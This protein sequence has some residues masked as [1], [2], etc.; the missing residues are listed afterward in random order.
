MPSIALIGFMGTGKTAVGRVLAERLG[1]EFIDLDAVIEEQ[2]GI[3]IAEIFRR[4]GE[5]HF[6]KLEQ[7][8]VAE[9]SQR[10][11]VVLAAG[12]GAVLDR[13]NV[14]NLKRMGPVVHLMAHPEM[15]VRRIAG[16]H[17]RPL[18]EVEDRRGRIENL[19]A[20]RLPFYAVADMDIDTSGL[21]VKK[22]VERIIGRLKESDTG[23]ID[24]G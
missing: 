6:R 21:S 1:Q 11:D 15:I 10:R 23:E 13:E 20:V 22:V 4:H 9:V 7:K 17:H 24:H 19:L 16:Q 12:G 18:M 3:S 8:A 5:A 14:V 2:E